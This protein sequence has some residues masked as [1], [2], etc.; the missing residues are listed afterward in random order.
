MTKYIVDSAL[1]LGYPTLKTEQLQIVSMFMTGRDV[2]G[3]LPTG[4]GKSLCFVILPLCFVAKRQTSGSIVVVV[5]PLIAIMENLVE[6][7]IHQE[8]FKYSYA[9]LLHFTCF[10]VLKT[11]PP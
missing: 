4:Y 6:G 8:R 5:T 2:F 3:I 11:A 10:H 7:R 1:A 9:I